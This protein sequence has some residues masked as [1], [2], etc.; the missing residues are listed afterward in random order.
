MRQTLSETQ[1]THTQTMTTESS[2]IIR[3]KEEIRMLNEELEE[4]RLTAEAA[5]Q[6]TARHHTMKLREAFKEIGSLRQQLDDKSAEEQRLREVLRE[7]MTKEREE[8]SK[9]VQE[10]I[11][12]RLDKTHKS[13]LQKQEVT[14]S[15]LRSF[16]RELQHLEGRVKK[17]RH[18]EDITVT[19]R[20]DD[21][22]KI[23]EVCEA[24][25]SLLLEINRDR[26]DTIKHLED[27]EER[28]QILKSTDVQCTYE[29]EEETNANY[30]A[31]MLDLL[32]RMESAGEIVGDFLEGQECPVITQWWTMKKN[33][34]DLRH[35]IV[36]NPTIC[37]E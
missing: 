34:L 3:L 30:R 2:E 16:E 1:S 9:A 6:A 7:H 23:D 20:E 26:Q 36:S 15:M 4:E 11:Q 28:E 10:I 31:D 12:N 5:L 27:I 18:P 24:L 13:R 35:L 19:M 14:F 32:S 25:D 37:S 21:R 8:K 22:H 17:A 33:M 29:K